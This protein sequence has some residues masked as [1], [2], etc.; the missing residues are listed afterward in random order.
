MHLQ[1]ILESSQKF[2]EIRGAG[3]LEHM[4]RLSGKGYN[5]SLIFLPVSFLGRSFQVLSSSGTSRTMTIGDPRVWGSR[6]D[7]GRVILVVLRL[8]EQP[9]AREEGAM[10]H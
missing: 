4:R 8:S 5:F 9:Q 7:E 1:W 3:T 10:L 2:C 6:I